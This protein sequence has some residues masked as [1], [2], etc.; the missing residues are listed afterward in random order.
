MKC[1]F[2]G[3]QNQSYRS[4]LK[5]LLMK[6]KPEAGRNSAL[7]WTSSFISANWQTLPWA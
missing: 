2:A 7:R 1:K 6:N 5:T 3:N 4:V